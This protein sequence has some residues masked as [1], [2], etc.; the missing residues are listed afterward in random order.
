MGWSIDEEGVV[1]TSWAAISCWLFLAHN[2]CAGFRHGSTVF[3]A[4][5]RPPPSSLPQSQ[6]DTLPHSSVDNPSPVSSAH[7]AS[8]AA[9]VPRV[10]QAFAHVSRVLAPFHS[11]VS[12]RTGTSCAA[13]IPRVPRS[14]APAHVVLRI[15]GTPPVSTHGTPTQRPDSPVTCSR[16]MLA[17]LSERVAYAPE[18]RVRAAVGVRGGRAEIRRAV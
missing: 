7:C 17:S 8:F 3:K 1:R 9:R 12:R 11:S 16:E 5:A 2:V 4:A 14:Q 10:P 13:H 15:H 6:L 18:G